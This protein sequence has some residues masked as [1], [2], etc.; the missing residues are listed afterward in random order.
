MVPVA[1]TQDTCAALVGRRSGQV[2]DAGLTHHR[3]HSYL[4][5]RK[6]SQWVRLSSTSE[7][8]PAACLRH[9]RLCRAGELRFFERL[10][11]RTFFLWPVYTTHDDH[12]R[13]VHG[14]RSPTGRFP[15]GMPWTPLGF[16]ASSV[17]HYPV[18]PLRTPNLGGRRART[19]LRASR[20]AV[21]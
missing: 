12:I 19:T 4:P 5:S 17:S 15:R 18:V 16:V 13:C 11:A 21:Q 20:G 7:D 2:R 3:W 6:A 10:E 9:D 1:H 14:R 8:I